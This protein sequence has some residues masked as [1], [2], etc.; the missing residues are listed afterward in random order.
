M[1]LTNDY[2]SPLEPFH[3][4]A[5]LRNYPFLCLLFITPTAFL[6]CEMSANSF[7]KLM[8][9][10]AR[11]SNTTCTL[12]TLCPGYKLFTPDLKSAYLSLLSIVLAGIVP[13]THTVPS[14]MY[15]SLFILSST[16]I[17]GLLAPFLEIFPDAMEYPTVL[18][19]YHSP[20][21]E[22]GDFAYTK[23]ESFQIH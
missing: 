11:K 23:V 6:S 2:Y 8:E 20:N 1:E 16:L 5:I 17:S 18:S 10:A 12:L 3:N 15:H 19:L 14:I 22:L 13:G 9:C 4:F 21:M 7:A